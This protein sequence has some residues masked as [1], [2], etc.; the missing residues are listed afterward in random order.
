MQNIDVKFDMTQLLMDIA[1]IK[2]YQ[3]G[4]FR[5]LTKDLPVDDRE[6]HDLYRLRDYYTQIL[7]LHEAS[8]KSDAEVERILK[9]KLKEVK[10]RLAELKV[11]N[12]D[13]PPHQAQP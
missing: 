11:Q 8:S 3:R 1:E 9:E 12:P 2:A 6:K 4:I 13:T 5:L 10:D 7:T